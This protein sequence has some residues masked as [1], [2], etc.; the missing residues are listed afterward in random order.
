MLPA[1][2]WQ[3]ACCWWDHPSNQPHAMCYMCSSCVQSQVLGLEGQLEESMAEAAQLRLQV[4]ALEVRAAL[5][6]VAG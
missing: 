1:C 6:V 4:A 5:E 2:A 3:L